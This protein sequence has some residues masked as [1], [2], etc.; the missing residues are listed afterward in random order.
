MTKILQYYLFP[1]F[2][3]C[4][5]NP[6]YKNLQNINFEIILNEMSG[7]RD[8]NNLIKSNLKKYDQGRI[9]NLK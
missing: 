4:G 6:V 5:F 2:V 1:F 3:S 9:V 7:D 8:I